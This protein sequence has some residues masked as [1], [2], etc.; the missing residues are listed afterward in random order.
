MCCKHFLHVAKNSLLHKS[1]FLSSTA[2]EYRS[3]MLY[4]SLPV[5]HDILPD[6]YFTHYSLLVAAMHIMLGKTISTQ[7]LK[8]GEEYLRRFY[9]MFSSLYGKRIR[10][11]TTATM[12]LYMFTL[13]L[14]ENACTMNVHM[15]RH[16]PDCVR[17]WGPLW[18]YSCF[19]FESQNGH[20]K[21]LY[22]GTRCMN[23]Q[24]I[25][26]LQ[27]NNFFGMLLTVLC[28]SY[29]TVGFLI[30]SFTSFARQAKSKSIVSLPLLFI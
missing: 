11:C 1:M 14:G 4:F 29:Y 3:W 27:Q 19:S 7:R 28:L 22:H 25:I 26:Y 13:F 23:T 9:E 2:S 21:K 24:V 8:I 18:A 16:I 12:C 10:N 6:P 5:L 15:L 17:N 20:L 30:Y